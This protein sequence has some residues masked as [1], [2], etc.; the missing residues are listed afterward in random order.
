VLATVTPVY[1]VGHGVGMWR[2]VF[3]LLR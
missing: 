2:G 1:A 3:E